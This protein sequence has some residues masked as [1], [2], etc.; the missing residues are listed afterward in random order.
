MNRRG[1]ITST[2]ALAFVNKFRSRICIPT[3]PVSVLWG[4]G[5]HDDTAALNAWGA[6]RP[7][8]YPDGTPVTKVI[9]NSVFLITGTIHISRQDPGLMIINNHFRYAGPDLDRRPTLRSV[10]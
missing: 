5:R 10:A 6:G 9:A 8:V 1:F 3:A 7:V 2:L 4:D